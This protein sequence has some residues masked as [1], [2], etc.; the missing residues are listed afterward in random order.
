MKTRYVKNLEFEGESEFKLPGDIVEHLLSL[1]GFITTTIETLAFIEGV[2]GILRCDSFKMIK[3][4]LKE[5]EEK[6]DA[7]VDNMEEELAYAC[8]IEKSIL[9]DVEEV[10]EYIEKAEDRDV[11][12]AIRKLASL[13]YE[14]LGTIHF[15]TFTSP[16][17]ES[18]AR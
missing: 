5:L 13:L 7:C 3:K 6:F 11:N 18:D 1:A 9:W 10:V 12:H 4:R 15:Y 14:I 8:M 17:Y 2:K 16:F